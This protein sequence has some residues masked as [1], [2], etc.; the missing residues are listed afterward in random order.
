MSAQAEFHRKLL[1]RIEAVKVQ[2]KIAL[3]VI[4]VNVIEILK[5]VTSV[6]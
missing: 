2:F 5:P 3:E 6:K 1:P 4:T